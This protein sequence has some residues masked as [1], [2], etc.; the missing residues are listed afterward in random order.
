MADFFY[1]DFF[2]DE[3]DP[4]IELLVPIRG[5]Q[6]PISIK[7][8]VSWKDFS[9]AKEQAVTMRINPKNQQPE[10]VNYSDSIFGTELL[11]RCVK[12][13]PFKKRDGSPVPVTRET[14]KA[15]GT[16]GVANLVG[17][18]QQTVQQG[19]EALAPFVKPSDDPSSQT[20]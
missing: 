4:G 20:T 11:V 15:L 9:E 2:T 7:R 1:D 14:I 17:V 16:D 18:I 12:S 6:V 3:D 10:I 19:V 8:G 5:R 13:W